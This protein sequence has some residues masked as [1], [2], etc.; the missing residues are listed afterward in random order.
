MSYLWNVFIYEMSYSWKVLS[1][2]C[3]IYDTVIY[4]KSFYDGSYLWNV[5]IYEMSY[6][7]NVLS[8]TLLSMKSLS[9]KCP[10]YEMSLP[11]KFL[12]YEMSYLW[13][14]LSMKNFYLWNV[15]IYELFNLEMS[16]YMKFSI[17]EMSY[18]W[19]MM[20]VVF[21][22]LSYVAHSHVTNQGTLINVLRKS[23]LSKYISF[24]RLP[25][26]DETS[27]LQTT[28]RKSS[29]PL[30][31][32]WFPFIVNYNIYDIKSANELILFFARYTWRVSARH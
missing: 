10:I 2:K 26:K 16:L 8:M 28:V 9:M 21:E 11:M 1:M 3:S 13:N 7:W 30:S 25:T 29:S 27:D 31:N 22:K 14:L 32:S 19:C 6:Q 24:I 17:Y 23:K 20:N 5:F 4:E 18:L 12:I 15:F